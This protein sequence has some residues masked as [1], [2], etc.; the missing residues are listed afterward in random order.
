MPQNLATL[1][2]V[3]VFM[4]EASAILLVATGFIDVRFGRYKTRRAFYQRATLR[5]VLAATLLA[6]LV[7]GGFWA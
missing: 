7:W 6:I 4:F 1:Y 2:F 5:V 3:A